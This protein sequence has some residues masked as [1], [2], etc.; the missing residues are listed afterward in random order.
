MEKNIKNWGIRRGYIV[1][2]GYCDQLVSF[3]PV[4][5][6]WYSNYKWR[7][8]QW[9]TRQWR[10]RQCVLGNAKFFCDLWS[11]QK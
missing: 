7:T 1:H 11:P 5:M 6:M 10:T 3:L 9:R 8:R 4:F 2:K